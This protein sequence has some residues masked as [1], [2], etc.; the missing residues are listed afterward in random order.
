MTAKKY[1]FYIERP[2]YYKDYEQIEVEA[3]SDEEALD[4]CKK[5]DTWAKA[6]VTDYRDF[7]SVGEPEIV[8]RHEL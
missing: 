1:R 4:L 6:D 2:V 8:E 7:D 5:E 3:D